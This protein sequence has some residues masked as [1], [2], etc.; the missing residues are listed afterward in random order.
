VCYVDADHKDRYEE[1][2][3]V[4][5][6][7]EDDTIETEVYSIKEEGNRLRVILD[8]DYYYGNFAQL[9]T[10]EVSL[11]T[12]DQRGLIIENSSL[13]EKDDVQG[14]YVKSKTDDYEFVPVKVLASDGKQSLVEDE[15]FVDDQGESVSTV[16]LYDEILKEPKQSK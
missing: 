14:V 13:T 8:T 6:A 9:R 2:N 4:D 5:V 7:F 15:Y 16:E 1:G 11:I 10:A 12:Y 3:I